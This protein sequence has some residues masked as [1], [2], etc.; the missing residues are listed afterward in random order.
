MFQSNH[1][2][3][4]I[5]KLYIYIY[6]WSNYND[7]T[8]PHPKWWFS[9]GNPIIS[10]KSRLVKYYNLT[11]YIT[12]QGHCINIFQTQRQGSPLKEKMLPCDY[13][14][15]RKPSSPWELSSGCWAANKTSKQK[16][17][18]SWNWC[19]FDFVCWVRLKTSEHKGAGSLWQMVSVSAHQL[20]TKMTSKF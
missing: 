12:Y 13:P 8:R 7:L 11:R 16:K 1:H 15:W 20:V 17:Q 10:G 18:K 5:Y 19:L 3:L 14:I 6:I 2:F 4:W 9:K